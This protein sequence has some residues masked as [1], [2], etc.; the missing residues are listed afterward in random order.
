MSIITIM[1][2]S[3]MD[4]NLFLVL[5]AVL[6]E[7]SATRAARRLHVTQSAVSN[8]LARLREVLKDP[9][10]VRSGSGLAATPRAKELAPL[11]E[12]AVN[13]LQSVLDQERDVDPAQ[14]TRRFTLAC[15]DSQQIHD[16]PR[17]AKALSKRMPRARLRVVSIDYL[18]ANDGLRRGDVDVAMGPRLA[19][20]GLFCE[21]L[22][23]EDGVAVVRRD[24]PLVAKRMT[25]ELFNSLEHVDVLITLGQGGHG[26]SQAEKFFRKH[27][28]VR[29]VALAVP[30]F[31]A[32]ALTAVQ[33]DYVA[34]IPR[35]VAESLSQ[36]A[37]LKILELPV[38]GLSV[39]LTLIWHSR[40]RTDANIRLF[41]ELIVATLKKRG[42]KLAIADP[43][44]GERG[45]NSSQF[46]S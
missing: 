31:T 1:N 17:I 6:Q 5:H 42:P 43:P 12:S 14:C 28:L 21:D 20:P 35:G 3:N 25:S 4:L 9:L 10:V 30:S 29:N 41:R 2:L 46:L 39:G 18:L 44:A 34:C 22:Y 19:Q 26:H 45:R 27:R 23:R 32:A 24:H 16:V 7:G 40:S 38:R 13:Q 11:I 15:A 33:T 37:P 36:Y 8:S